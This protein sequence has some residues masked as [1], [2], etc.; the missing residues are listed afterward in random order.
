MLWLVSELGIFRL[1]LVNLPINRRGGT[2][3]EMSSHYIKTMLKNIK[4]YPNS[5]IIL[6]IF[7]QHQIPKLT[8]CLINNI[9]QL[10]RI[11]LV[12]FIMT[13]KPYFLLLQKW[14]KLP[15]HK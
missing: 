1:L 5:E 2:N 3:L 15:I 12:K 8:V 10:K 9:R 6:T 11:M 14:S 13:L 4:L 7:D